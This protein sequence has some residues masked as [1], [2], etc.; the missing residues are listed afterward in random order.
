MKM[1]KRAPKDKDRELRDPKEKMYKARSENKA[2]KE[3]KDGMKALKKNMPRKEP[4]EMKNADMGKKLG[5]EPAGKKGEMKNADMDKAYDKY[6]KM[7][8]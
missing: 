6:K 3:G 2:G 7:K 5:K 8:K 4:A 1:E